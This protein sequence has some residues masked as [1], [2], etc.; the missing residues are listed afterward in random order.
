MGR[1]KGFFDKLLNGENH[2]FVFED[3][4]PNDGITQGIGRNEEVRD[5][6]NG[7]GSRGCVD[8]FGRRR[9]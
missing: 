6:R 4:V 7:W 3:G 8:V 2:G 5:N 1:W 9:D